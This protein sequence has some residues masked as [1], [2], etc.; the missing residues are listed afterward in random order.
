MLLDSL[1]DPVLFELVRLGLLLK[2]S[3]LTMHFPPH[4]PECFYE[5]KKFK[6]LLH[7]KP[8]K[9]FHGFMF[10]K[11][12]K[13]ASLVVQWL[14]VCLAMQGTQVQSLVQGRSYMS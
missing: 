13:R 10:F 14:R 6:K 9:T 4:P 12:R 3:G 11:K 5:F 8:F 1:L 7:L 2:Q